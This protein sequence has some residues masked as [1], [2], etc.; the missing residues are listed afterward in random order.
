MLAGCVFEVF[1]G[2]RGEREGREECFSGREGC[3]GRGEGKEGKGEGVTGYHSFVIS[4]VR[5]RNRVCA[6]LRH[7]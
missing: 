7:A 5:M 1:S 4:D 2:G 3:S 6:V